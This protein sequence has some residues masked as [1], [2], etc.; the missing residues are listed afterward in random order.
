MM[1]IVISIQK[2]R[3]LEGTMSR[4]LIGAVIALL[5]GAA[6]KAMAYDQATEIGAKMYCILKFR[7]AGMDAMTTDP[8]FQNCVRKR[9]TQAS[10]EWDARVAAQQRINQLRQQQLRREYGN[11]A[12]TPGFLWWIGSMVRVSGSRAFSGSRRTPA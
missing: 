6:S 11:Q 3:N 1:Y 2:D 5:S 12:D 7:S 8:L 10:R 4:V 9:A